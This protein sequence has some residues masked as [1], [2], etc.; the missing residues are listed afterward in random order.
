MGKIDIIMKLDNGKVDYS[1][2]WDK[3][4]NTD[5]SIAIAQLEKLKLK[6]LDK[7]D[8]KEFEYKKD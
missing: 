3:P 6:L 2:T 5:F 1:V 4:N 8:N 7:I